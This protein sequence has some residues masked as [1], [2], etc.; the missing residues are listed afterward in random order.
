P[1]GLT[2]RPPPLAIDLTLR[3]YHGQA[4]RDPAEVYRGQAKSGTSHFHAYATAYVVRRGRR[5]T[6][7]LTAV[8]RGEALDEVVRRL[9]RW[10]GRAGVRPRYVLLDRGFCSVAVTR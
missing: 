9:L 10:A 6:V 1:R 7:A 5:S 3:P 2:S 4:L 8:Y